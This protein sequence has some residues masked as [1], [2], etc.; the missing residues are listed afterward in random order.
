MAESESVISIVASIADFCI[1]V[2][3]LSA[4]VADEKTV[5]LSTADTVP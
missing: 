4:S 1:L 5:V 2:K 3:D